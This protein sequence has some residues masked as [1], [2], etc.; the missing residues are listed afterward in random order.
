[1]AQQLRTPPVQDCGCHAAPIL[2]DLAASFLV[3][4]GLAWFLSRTIPFA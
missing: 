2:T 4:E 3:A 1:V